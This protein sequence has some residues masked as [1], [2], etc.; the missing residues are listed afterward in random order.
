MWH[1]LITLIAVFTM[2]FSGGLIPS[3]LLMQK[4]HLMNTVWVMMIPTAVNVYNLIIARSF[5]DNLPP[6][7]RQR[8]ILPQ[9]NAET[10]AKN[11]H[12]NTVSLCRGGRFLSGN[13]RF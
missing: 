6:F 12:R 5:M 9:T 2:Y 8:R 1:K 13:M 10:H 7:L 3:Y 4:L 11:A